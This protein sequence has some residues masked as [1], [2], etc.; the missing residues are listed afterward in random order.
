MTFAARTQSNSHS[1]QK[2]LH[3]LATSC[4]AIKLRRA[5]HTDRISLRMTRLSDH[6]TPAA[7]SRGCPLDLNDSTPR[8]LHDKAFAKK[9]IQRQMKT[10]WRVTRLGVLDALD[11][12]A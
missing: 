10:V 11:I 2:T 3:S 9:D 6:R 8:G 1:P 7:D 4:Q 5:K 12:T